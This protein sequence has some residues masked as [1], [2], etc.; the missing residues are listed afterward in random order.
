MSIAKK[1]KSCWNN[2]ICSL[3]LIWP[4][5][6][7][8]GFVIGCYG[9]FTIFT[10]IDRL[11]SEFAS[12]G[13]DIGVLST[14]VQYLGTA[15]FLTD[16]VV[17]LYGLREKTRTRFNCFRHV[18]NCIACFFKF[19]FKGLVH[20]LVTTSC[21]LALLIVV[22]TEFIWVVLLTTDAAC[23]AGE[24]AVGSILDI[25]GGAGDNPLAEICDTVEGAK[26]GAQNLFIGS[27]ILIVGQGVV[28]AYWM[29]YS[30]LAMAAPFFV[31]MVRQQGAPR[32]APAAA[33]PL[34]DELVKNQEAAAA[35]EPREPLVF[36]LQAE[37]EE[38][39]VDL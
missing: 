39:E 19:F 5:G 4:I 20:M 29:K 26:A 18:D 7:I 22:F 9:A 10:G 32:V 24:D 34:P 16:S 27:V 13:M 23:G 21:V 36:V 25:L 6:G 35:S 30:T 14:F 3:L 31:D 12:I 15:V 2:P 28:L 11:D 33:D 17:L 1:S 37:K 8:V 38:G